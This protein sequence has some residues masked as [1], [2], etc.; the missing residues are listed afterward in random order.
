MTKNVTSRVLAWVDIGG[1]TSLL[2]DEG[3]RPYVVRTANWTT[4]ETTTGSACLHLVIVELLQFQNGVEY[5]TVVRGVANKLRVQGKKPGRRFFNGAGNSDDDYD[6]S[7]CD[8]SNGN[9]SGGICADE[10][11]IRK[12]QD[13]KE[14][15]ELNGLHQLLVYADDVNMLGENPQTIREN[16][17]I[18][19]EASKAIGL[20]VNPERPSARSAL[21][22]RLPI[23]F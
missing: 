10:Y 17:E 2:G 12:V 18:L 21:R 15:L 16:A 11:A 9:T 5:R 4:A 7:D 23:V 6:Y 1:N 20:K 8:D 14:G 3:H 19:L 22:I 13:N